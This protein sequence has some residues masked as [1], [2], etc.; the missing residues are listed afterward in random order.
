MG[1]RL[2]RGASTVNVID[3]ASTRHV[4]VMNNEIPHGL[5]RCKHPTPDLHEHEARKRRATPSGS[6]AARWAV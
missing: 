1:L 5:Y 2:Q 4:D 3:V 6:A